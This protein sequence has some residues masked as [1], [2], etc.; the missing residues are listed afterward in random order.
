[1]RCLKAYLDYRIMLL[2]WKEKY[3]PKTRT[4]EW[5]DRF[6]TALRELVIVNYYLD[7]LLFGEP[8]DKETIV[9]EKREEIENIERKCK[10]YFNE[11]GKRF[12][13]ENDSYGEPGG[14][15]GNQ[16]NPEY[17]GKGT[18]KNSMENYVTVLRKDPLLVGSLR[19]NRLTEKI[20]VT[21]VLWWNKEPCVLTNKGRKALRYFFENIMVCSMKVLWTMHWIWK[22]TV[23]NTT[24]FVNI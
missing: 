19:Y 24:P 5:N 18:V 1:M 15:S 8:A 3:R 4:E 14:L 6:T 9:R 16:R 12:D 17:D 21:K 22:H 11:R 10:R 2:E 23:K 7:T 13:K 20:D